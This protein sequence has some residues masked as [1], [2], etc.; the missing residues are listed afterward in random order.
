MRVLAAFVGVFALSGC[1]TDRPEP[2]AYQPYSPPKPP[3]Y[4][5]QGATNEEF[6]RTKAGCM[7]KAEI[8][9]SSSTDPN[10]LAK[11]VTNMLVFGNCMRADG[12]VLMQQ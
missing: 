7:M 5:K 3:A 4:F 8:A 10:Q 2:V 9:E 6:Q 11:S 12:W 1:V